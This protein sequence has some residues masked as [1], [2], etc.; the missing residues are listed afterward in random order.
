MQRNPLKKRHAVWW[1]GGVMMLSAGMAPWS[2]AQ[3]QNI[4]P[5]TMQQVVNSPQFLHRFGPLAPFQITAIQG[6]PDASKAALVTAI[7]EVGYAGLPAAQK[8]FKKLL[9][10]LGIPQAVLRGNSFRLK[11]T[12]RHQS[13]GTASRP[14]LVFPVVLQESAHPYTGPWINKG[15][16]T[17][18]LSYVGRP[19]NKPFGPTPALSK[20]TLVRQ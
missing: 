15:A 4:R 10:H 7:N 14:V 11:Q 2:A 5:M 3:A 1:I 20:I 16:Y 18:R 12:A 8:D 9:Y 13:S 17:L 6:N 19:A